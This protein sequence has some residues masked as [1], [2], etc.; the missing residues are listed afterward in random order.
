LELRAQEGK[1]AV[2]LDEKYLAAMKL[3][4]PYGAGM[5]LGFDRLVML[6]TDQSDISSVLAFGWDEV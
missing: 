5:A 1:D 4:S 2:A 3:G 6:L